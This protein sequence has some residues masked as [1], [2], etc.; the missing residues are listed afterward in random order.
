MDSEFKI[1]KPIPYYRLTDLMEYRL[2][3]GHNRYAVSADGCVLSFIGKPHLLKQGVTKGGYNNVVIDGNSTY[4]HR[5]VAEA[6]I[7]NP[8]SKPQIDHIN[9]VRTQNN[10]E[11]LRWVT[12]GENSRNP[13]SIEHYREGNKNKS[14]HLRKPVVQLTLDGEYIRTWVSSN[15]AMAGLGIAASNIRAA[16]RN[17]R[18]RAGMF[19]WVFAADF[20]NPPKNIRKIR[21]IS[22]IKPLF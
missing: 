4:V 20:Q 1:L 12:S 17:K 19:R 6:F 11:N 13:L 2:V 3:K 14:A 21:K 5:L 10:A 18:S 9:T 16:C 15:E 22:D 7:P 8:K